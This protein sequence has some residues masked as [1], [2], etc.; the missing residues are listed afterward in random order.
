LITD[1]AKAYVV[2]PFSPREPVAR[3]NTLLGQGDSQSAEPGAS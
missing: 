3:V 1:G 2:K